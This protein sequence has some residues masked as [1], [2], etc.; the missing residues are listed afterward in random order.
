MKRREIK[1][2]ETIG[3][4]LRDTLD[5]VKIDRVMIGDLGQTTSTTSRPRKKREPV[6][7]NKLPPPGSRNARRLDKKKR[8]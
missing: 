5:G 7:V 3:E 2:Y 1:H 6:N 4:M 8:R